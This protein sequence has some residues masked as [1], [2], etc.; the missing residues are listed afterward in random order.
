MNLP[1]PD[2]MVAPRYQDIGAGQVALLSS[3][4]GGALVRVIAGDVGGHA[5]PGRDPHP[6]GHG[7]RHRLAPAP[8]SG[9]RGTRTSTRSV[10]VLAGEGSVGPD[11]RPVRMGQLAVFGPGDTSSV[12]ARDRQESVATN[13]TCSCSAAGP[14]GSRS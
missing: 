3:P 2:K 10:Y 12:S 14:S 9:C 13:S 7:A 6:D 4:D 5:G 8:G 11:G 1:G